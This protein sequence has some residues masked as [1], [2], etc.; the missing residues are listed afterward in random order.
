MM[1]GFLTYVYDEPVQEPKL[2]K[3]N[4]MAAVMFKRMDKDK[5]GLVDSNEMP[6]SIQKQ[7]DEAGMEIRG[8]LTPLM[9]EAL[10][11]M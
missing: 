11:S 5:D 4:A 1:Y 10:M 8:G 2:S 9:L 6:A 7:L 3:P